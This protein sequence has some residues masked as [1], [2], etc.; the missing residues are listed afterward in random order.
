MLKRLREGKLEDRQ[1]EMDVSGDSSGGMMQIFGPMGQMEEIGGIMQDLMN[2]LP[3]KSKKRRVTIAEARRILEQEEVQKL[4]DM[5][6]V[7][8]EAII[9]VEQVGDSF[10]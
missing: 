7:V 8:K 6:S 3:R 4:I 9:K 5:D 1:I 2:G 10:H